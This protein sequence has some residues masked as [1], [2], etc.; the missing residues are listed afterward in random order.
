MAL[1]SA[2]PRFASLSHRPRPSSW[3]D[4]QFHDEHAERLRLHSSQAGT[5]ASCRL[6]YRGRI[7]S[8]LSDGHPITLAKA[9][10][11]TKRSAMTPVRVMPRK[12][13]CMSPT[14]PIDRWTGSTSF[15]HW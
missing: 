4:L 2:P 11:D 10:R 7:Y 8:R 9:T 6:K 3:S 13:Y 12:T 1:P 14:S 5:L 15:L